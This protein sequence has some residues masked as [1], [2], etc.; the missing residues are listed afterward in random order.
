MQKSKLDKMTNDH[1]IQVKATPHNWPRSGKSLLKEW[2]VIVIDMQNDYCLKGCYMDK[3]GF[4]VNRLRKP[5]ENIV[6]VIGCAR[7]IGI[8]VIYSRHGELETSSEVTASSKGQIGW[9]LIDELNP[10][11]TEVIFDK[12]TT[13]VF[14]SSDIDKYLKSKGIKYLAFCGNTIDCCVHSSLRSA[15]DLGYKCLLLSDCCGGVSD[16]LYNWSIES[17]IV[18]DGVFGVVTDSKT[19]IESIS[20][21]K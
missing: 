18:E 16:N 13:S 19:F 9:K 1:L 5:I 4:D 3:A 8:E 10:R 21:V 11:D 17:I 7:K 12:S 2:A 20:I 14:M 6:N 15:N